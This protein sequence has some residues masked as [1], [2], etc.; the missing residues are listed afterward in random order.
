MLTIARLFGKSPFAPLQTHMDKV[1]SCLSE[2]PRLFKALLEQD[3]QI[4]SEI[5]AKIAHL[6]HEADLTKNDIRNHLPNSIFLPLDRSAL[7]D[8]LSL[9]DSLADQA[10]TISRK[11]EM[12]PL[13]FPEN[14]Q[15]LFASLCQ[16]NMEV[17]WLTREVIQE[18]EELLESSFGGIEAEKVKRMVE[19][20]AFLEYETNLHQHRFL[21]ILYSKETEM[22]YG[23]FHLLLN[24]VEEVGEISKICENLGNRI[25]MLLDLR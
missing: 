8:I 13:S 5:T 15:N 1:S 4:I 23:A 7:L 12:R 14:M 18:L 24:L 19:Q 10:E 20:I 25:R 3:A 9:Q 21:K 6:E 2:L 17:F 22:S 11:A 16:R